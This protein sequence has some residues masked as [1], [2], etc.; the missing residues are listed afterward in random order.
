MVASAALLSALALWSAQAAMRIDR[1]LLA[2]G[3][4]QWATGQL[5]QA[6]TTFEQ[7]I[8]AEPKS[9]KAHMKLAGLQLSR[10]DFTASIPT[11]QAA[12]GLDANHDKAWLGI[13]FAY[14]HTGQDALA[15]AAFDAAIRI[16]PANRDKLA[17]VL[18]KLNVR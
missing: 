13:A 10:Q 2:Q 16:N 14:L 17:P 4:Q 7:A 5:D 11:Y 6:Q 18:D 9:L 15:G 1:N 12:I 3:D 8:R